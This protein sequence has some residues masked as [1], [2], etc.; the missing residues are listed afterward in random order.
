MITQ[1]KINNFKVKPVDVVSI[2]SKN[3]GGGDL[4]P[5]FC[6]NVLIVS[7]KKTGKSTIVKNIIDKCANKNTHVW[8][9]CPSYSKDGCYKEIIKTLEK[10]KM[11]FNCFYSI[12]DEEDGPI[13]SQLIEQLR[14]ENDEEVTK[15][16]PI[17]KNEF[18]SKCKF[19]N[20]SEA[21]LLKI[22][23]QKKEKEEKQKLKKEQM[24]LKKK[25]I[26]GPSISYG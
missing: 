16:E 22:E 21:Q 3:I 8:I 26:S 1:T 2:D 12:D 10:R 6:P 15:K 7:R 17:T 24:E 5:E 19:S 4:F 23:E 13:L 14:R 11:K 25:N 9:F 20:L 18:T